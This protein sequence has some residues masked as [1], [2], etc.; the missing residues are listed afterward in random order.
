MST[1]A[2]GFAEAFI[3]KETLAEVMKH[4]SKIIVMHKKELSIRVDMDAAAA[5][6]VLMKEQQK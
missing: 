6:Y 5:L 1:T 4:L 2:E 3:N